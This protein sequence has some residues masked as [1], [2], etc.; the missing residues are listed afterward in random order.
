MEIFLVHK[1]ITTNT[2][3][4]ITTNNQIAIHKCMSLCCVCVS[5]LSRFT[6]CLV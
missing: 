1:K 3:K 5:D 2:Y 6:L 4:Y